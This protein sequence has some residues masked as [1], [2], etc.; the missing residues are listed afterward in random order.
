[1]YSCLLNN[2]YTFMFW[3]FPYFC[4]DAFKVVCCKFAVCGKG[5]N[6]F[7]DIDA[8]WRLCSRQLFE[9]I[10]TKEEI[11]QNKQFLLLL[12][13]FPLLVIGYPYN[14]RDFLFFDK[15]CSKSSAAELLFEGKGKQ[16]LLNFT[17]SVSDSFYVFIYIICFI[18]PFESCLVWECSVVLW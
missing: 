14:Y 8:F 10:V 16:K 2:K 6:P 18:W 4:L 17:Q 13:C 12:Q 1:M 7:P 9:N 5:F 15:I 3:Y 11:A